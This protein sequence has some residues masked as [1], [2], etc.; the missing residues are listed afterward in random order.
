MTGL[1][2]TG[3]ARRGFTL[4]ELLVVVVIAAALT[5]ITLLTLSGH[6]RRARLRTTADRIERLDAKARAIARATSSPVAL[7]LEDGKARLIAGSA[8]ESVPVDGLR[9]DGRVA[10]S[11]AGR[12]ATYRVPLRSGSAELH[13][14]VL[15][16]TG[17]AYR[18]DDEG[19]VSAA[20]SP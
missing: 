4:V 12:S 8:S 14:L 17:Q 10:Y 20:L 1:A 3:P 15:G 2:A 7:S 6:V 9:A 11:P 5:A 19:A 18:F 16:Q 13:L